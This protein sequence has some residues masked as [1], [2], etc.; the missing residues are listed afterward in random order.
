MKQCR[1]SISRTNRD[2]VYIVIKDDDFK[3]ILEAEMS[4][5]DYARL[6]TNIDGEQITSEEFSRKHHID[7]D[8]FVYRRLKKN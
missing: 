5:I 6:I 4:L 8:M 1:I 2:N 3:V 7:A